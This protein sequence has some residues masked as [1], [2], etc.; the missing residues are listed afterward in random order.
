MPIYNLTKERIDELQAEQ[1]DLESQ[2]TSL[3]GK[4]CR[5]LWMDDIKDFEKEY[6]SFMKSYY[7][8]QTLNPEDY[9]GNG[10]KIPRVMNMK[11][12]KSPITAK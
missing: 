2:I 9:A 1:K 8:D 6:I 7:E 5:D 4:T 11:K 3:N 12:K 10:I